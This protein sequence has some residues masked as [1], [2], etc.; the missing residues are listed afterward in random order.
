AR[1]A[2]ANVLGHITGVVALGI[3][4]A[5]LFGGGVEVTT[6]GLEVGGVTDRVLVDVGGG[7]AHGKVLKID[8]DDELI[9]LA[10]SKRG[11]AG[12]FAVRGLEGDS[13]GPFGRFCKDGNGE[14]ADG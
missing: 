4:G 9:V 13:E 12:I 5:V 2:A 3:Q 7:L 6:G 1:A 10:G 14:H 11:G 8:L